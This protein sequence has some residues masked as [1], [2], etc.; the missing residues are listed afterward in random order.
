MS[1]VLNIETVSGYELMGD[2]LVVMRC[3][4]ESGEERPY[5][6]IHNYSSTLK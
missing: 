6:T 4:W 2:W 1:I 3:Y 5:D